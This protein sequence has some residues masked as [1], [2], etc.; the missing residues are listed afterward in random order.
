V[1]SKRKF[2]A[3]EFRVLVLSEE[4]LGDVTL[5]QIAYEVDQGACVGSG[6]QAKERKVGGKAMA[7]LLCDLGSEPGFF[8]LDGDGRDT[9]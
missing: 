5:E 3:T 8:R 2:Y 6:L 9:D 4:P 1:A 7:K